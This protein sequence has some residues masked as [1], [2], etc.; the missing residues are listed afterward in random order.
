MHISQ[1]HDA[2]WG[3]LYVLLAAGLGLSALLV[4]AA[5]VPRI[6]TRLTPHLDEEREI[7]QGNAAAGAYFGRVA[8]ATILGMSIIIAAAII[9]GLH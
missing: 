6:L 5:F 7:A 9:A 4:G 2:L 1:G 3:T 8:G